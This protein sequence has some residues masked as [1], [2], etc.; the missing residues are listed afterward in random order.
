[1]FQP[2]YYFFDAQYKVLQGKTNTA[3]RLF[4]QI[5]K[6]QSDHELDPPII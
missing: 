2:F 5:I 1:V 4:I 3:L 6:I